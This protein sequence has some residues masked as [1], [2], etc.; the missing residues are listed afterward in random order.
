MNNL[1][2]KKESQNSSK[3]AVKVSVVSI[4]GNLILTF[5]KLFAGI[6]AHS[7]AMVSDAIHSASDVVSSIVVIIGVKISEKKEDEDHPYGHERFESVAAIILSVMLVVVGGGIGLRA[8]QS[9]IN[10]SYLNMEVPG[11]LALIASGV[12]IVSKTAMF[13]YTRKNAK[14]IQSPALKADAWHHLSDALSSVG[15]LIGI[16]GAMLGVAV[17]EPIASAVI[18]IMILKA[19]ADIFIDAMNQM[20]DKSA[21]EEIEQE[22][23]DCAEKQEGVLGVDLLHTRMFGNKIYVDIEICL[24]RNLTLEKA[25]AIAETVHAALEKNFPRIKHVMVHVNPDSERRSE[26]FNH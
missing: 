6:F 8:V 2:Y 14:K 11:M 24:D 3:I 13:F 15:A 5:F 12:S 19:A 9:I 22:I 21:G 1:R 7:G 23:R 20:L 25:H 10:G 17:M 26:P 18:C 16:G 4:I